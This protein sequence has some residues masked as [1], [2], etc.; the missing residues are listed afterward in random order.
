MRTL[1]LTV[2]VLACAAMGAVW[3]TGCGAS[4]SD[5]TAVVTAQNVYLADC[6][7]TTAQQVTDA[8]TMENAAIQALTDSKTV[9]TTQEITDLAN[10]AI[11]IAETIIQMFPG[12]LADAQAQAL[13]SDAMKLKSA[14]TPGDVSAALYSLRA[15]SKALQARLTAATK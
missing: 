10:T 13:R 9:L 4:T 3:L 12:L 2:V 8:T 5:C 1:T 11:Q 7:P 6:P 14:N 15:S